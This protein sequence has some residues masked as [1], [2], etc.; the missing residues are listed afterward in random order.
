MSDRFFNGSIQT[1]SV[2]HCIYGNI[3]VKLWADPHIK[4]SFIWWLGLNI[5]LFAIFNI[6]FNSILKIALQ[7]LNRISLI[8]Q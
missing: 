5:S 2:F 1:F 4:C 3:P 6:F 7:L 8:R